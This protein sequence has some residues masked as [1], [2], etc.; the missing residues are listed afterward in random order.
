VASLFPDISLT[1]T[2]GLRNLS[3]GYLFDWD[4]KFYTFGPSISIPIFHGGA[5]VS[6]V[7]L[8]R[9][10]AAEA[11]L[12]YHKT[13]LHAL[14]EVED[15]LTGLHQDAAR[16]ASLRDTVTADQRALDADLD[17]YRHGLIT[18]I[19]VLTVQIQMVQARQQLAQA[20]L[21]QNTDLVKL[22]K[23]LGGG[24]EDAPA[25]TDANQDH[26]GAGN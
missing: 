19:T 24:W 12:N 25:N 26:S 20:L 18:Y 22:Y 1:G 4:S 8:S 9:A 17:G 3:P 10:M 16:T 7:R 15:S 13:V 2:F 6:N 14:E 21:A 5:L 11:A 23:A